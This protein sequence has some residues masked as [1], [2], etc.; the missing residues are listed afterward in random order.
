MY[1]A[2]QR[3]STDY[4]GLISTVMGRGGRSIPPTSQ[5]KK[6]PLNKQ[7]L[8]GLNQKAPFIQRRDRTYRVGSC[9]VP[10]VTDMRGDSHQCSIVDTLH[11]QRSL[12]YPYK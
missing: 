5:Q 9:V 1:L 11:C 3:E 8:K 2:R 10:T 6:R 12:E 4:D 7:R